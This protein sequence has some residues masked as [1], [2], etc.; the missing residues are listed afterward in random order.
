[1]NMATLSIDAWPDAVSM[2]SA[3][4]V[5]MDAVSQRGYRGAVRFSAAPYWN[6]QRFMWSATVRMSRRPSTT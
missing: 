3:L 1:M 6:G 4:A 2:R 5:L